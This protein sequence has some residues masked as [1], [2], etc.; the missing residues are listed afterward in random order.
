MDESLAREL[1]KLPT[2]EAKGAE[3]VDA[4]GWWVDE[5]DEVVAVAGVAFMAVS[6]FHILRVP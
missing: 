2:F 4:V 6:S 5:G 1:K 3:E